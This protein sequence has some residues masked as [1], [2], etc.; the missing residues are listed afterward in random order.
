M[1]V[2]SFQLLICRVTYASAARF[3]F[4]KH[5]LFP[6]DIADNQETVRFTDRVPAPAITGDCKLMLEASLPVPSDANRGKKK[7]GPFII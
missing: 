2:S 5:K 3:L 1:E 7:T 6:Y 4:L